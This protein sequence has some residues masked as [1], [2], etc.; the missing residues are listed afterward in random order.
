MAFDLQRALQEGLGSRIPF[1]DRLLSY[2]YFAEMSVL[3]VAF[4]D[5]Q[6]RG[7]SLVGRLGQEAPEEVVLVSPLPPQASRRGILEDPQDQRRALRLIAAT[8]ALASL[9]PTGLPAPAVG[10]LA[11]HPDPEGEVLA[12]LTRE[13]DLLRPRRYLLLDESPCRRAAP[14]GV[15]GLLLHLSAPLP[16]RPLPRPLRDIQVWRWHL[17]GS[18]CFQAL[19][20]VFRLHREGSILPLVIGPRSGVLLEEPQDLEVTV[21]VIDGATTPPPGWR[22]VDRPTHVG[23][24]GSWGDRVRALDEGL[25]LVFEA[26]RRAWGGTVPDRAIRVVGAGNRDPAGLDVLLWTPAGTM[27]RARAFIQAS[28]PVDGLVISVVQSRRA[29]P[30]TSDPASGAD[31][32]FPPGMTLSIPEDVPVLSMGSRIEGESDPVLE[33]VALARSLRHWIEEILG[34]DEGET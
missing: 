30:L 13:R 10:L 17:A 2:C 12:G 22:Q 24:Q 20:D 21:G 18:G 33:A 16:V 5:S 9:Q 32:P 14:V 23:T 6:G 11:V 7:V 28:P 8:W 1:L 15:D 34:P 4:Y 26:G 27:E 25:S 19:R 31:A 3:E 29:G